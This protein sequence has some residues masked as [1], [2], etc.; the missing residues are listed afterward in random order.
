MGEFFETLSYEEFLTLL[1]GLSFPPLETEDRPLQEAV[2]R[3]LAGSVTG[4][5]DLPGFPRSTMDGFALRCQESAGASPSSP[6]LLKVTGEVLM[7]KVPE[8]KVGPGE[9]WRIPTGGMV[10]EGADGVAMVEW[11]EENPPWVELFHAVAPG[12]NIL[13]GNADYSRGQSLFEPGQRLEPRQV[14]LLKALGIGRVRVKRPPRI[15]LLS[16]GDECVP[17]ESPRVWG[18]IRDTKS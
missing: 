12:A 3:I 10:P 4:E 13:A 15:A 1:D 11:A 17:P 7:G 16:T 6:V 9:A 2:D 14:Q 8:G 18:E 5:E